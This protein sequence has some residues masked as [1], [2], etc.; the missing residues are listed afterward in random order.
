MY[1]GYLREV[2]MGKHKLLYD[3]KLLDLL[4]ERTFINDA[5]SSP[6]K[7][8][9]FPTPTQMR[10]IEYI[11]DTNNDIYQKDLEGVLGLRRATVSEVLQTMEKNKLIERVS[12]E[13]DSRRKKIILKKEAEN[14]FLRH[15]KQMSEIEK[16]VSNGISKEDLYV[17]SKTIESMKNN[18]SHYN[19]TCTLRKDGK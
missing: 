1:Y 2:N 3:I 11:M 19:S 9:N 17:F 12:S 4:I 10:I 8:K 13:D 5:L 14:I 7:V 16:I 18:I 6:G 15:K